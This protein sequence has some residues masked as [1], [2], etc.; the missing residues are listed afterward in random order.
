MPAHIYMR[1][2]HYDGASEAN[3]KAAEVD[4]AYFKRVPPTGIYSM[5]YYPHNLQFLC[6]SAAMEG[7]SAEAVKAADRLAAS[8]PDEAVHD[9]PM[10]ELVL[11]L[12]IFSRARFGLWD[13]LM[14][15]KAPPADQRY[16]TAIWRWGRAMAQAAK[17][18]IDEADTEKAAFEAAAAKVPTDI[19][20]TKNT[21]GSIVALARAYLEGDLLARRFRTE[22]AIA[23][24]REAVKLEDDLSYDEPPFW[25]APVRHTL[26]AVLFD[27][28]RYDE[29]EA[30]YRED[31]KVYP[32]N[33]WSLFGLAQCL[34]AR[35]APDA[36]DVQKRFEKAW[37]KAD[38]KLASSRF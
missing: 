20:F 28:K 4:E 30:V 29:A 24:L 25:Y 27:A 31:L 19:V 35:N 3:I 5:M 21:S 32:E 16:R 37:A 38:V 17:G 34:K 9:M 26:G 15:F 36:A 7:R 13:D 2:G 23:K 18:H 11:P 33:G 10:V 6:S 12:T 22:Q 1:T 14:S 8:V